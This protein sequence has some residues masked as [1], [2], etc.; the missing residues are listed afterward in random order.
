MI[1]KLLSVVLVCL[2]GILF[3]GCDIPFY[4]KYQVEK[5]LTQAEAD[6]IQS[7]TELE[8]A[9]EA[10]FAESPNY[11]E[12]KK[13]IDSASEK[14]KAYG[15]ALNQQNPP[16]SAQDLHLNLKNYYQELIDFSGEIK[17]MIDFLYL[18]EKTSD[19][20]VDSADKLPSDFNQSVASLTKEF[21]QSKKQYQEDLKNI[22]DRKV[23]EYF[24]QAQIALVSVVEAYIDYLNSVITG[25]KVQDASYFDI[26][27]FVRQMDDGIYKFSSQLE[28]IERRGNFDKKAESL[29]QK[30]DEITKQIQDLKSKYKL[31]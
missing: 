12:T 1:K 17:L 8:K 2:M 18:T 27:Q 26:D 14:I 20:L 15:E 5:Y 25:L 21:T 3:S 23:P 30:Q 31:P 28:V 7:K 10:I 19:D 16:E 13:A 24:Y 22:E 9:T 29:S 11:E 6:F 4:T